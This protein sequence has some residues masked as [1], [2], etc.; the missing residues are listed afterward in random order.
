MLR[1]WLSHPHPSFEYSLSVFLPESGVSEAAALSRADILE[2]LQLGSSA[3]IS[4]RPGS[5]TPEDSD[6][7]LILQLLSGA[8]LLGCRS[9]VSVSCQTETLVPRAS[10]DLGERLQ[11]SPVDCRRSVAVCSPPD[12]NAPSRHRRHHHHHPQTHPPAPCP[13]LDKRLRALN[14]DLLVR[15]AAERGAPLRGLEDRMSAYQR[16]CDA[17]ANEE[18]QVTPQRWVRIFTHILER[19][20]VVLPRARIQHLSHPRARTPPAHPTSGALLDACRRRFCT[21]RGLQ[22]AVARVRRVELAVVRQEESAKYRHELAAAR[23]DL[24]SE[25]SAR[26]AQLQVA[27]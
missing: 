2:A 25:Y 24:Q 3:L 9:P 1:P 16:E 12:K 14:D 15:T 13:A 19:C 4:A 18:I 10:E 8:S 23:S 21:T 20:R 6:A 7:P 11:L 17:R 5:P 22:E 26:L 27:K